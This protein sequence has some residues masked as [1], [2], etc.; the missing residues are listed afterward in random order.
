MLCTTSGAKLATSA[1]LSGERPGDR[2]QRLGRTWMT[3]REYLS[4]E[5]ELA[6]IDRVTVDDV[7]RVL[8]SFPIAPTTWGRLGPG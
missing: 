8:G 2:M 7:K 4:L 5:D 6:M 1:T 3:R